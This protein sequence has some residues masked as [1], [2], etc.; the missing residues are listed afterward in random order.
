M[1]A[2]MALLDSNGRTWQSD[3][4]KDWSEE[5]VANFAEIAKHMNDLEH[6]AIEHEGRVIY[7]SPR[8]VVAIWLQPVGRF[9]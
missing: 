3:E 2:R 9:E 5:E 1:K 4:P 6:L 8:H 7:F